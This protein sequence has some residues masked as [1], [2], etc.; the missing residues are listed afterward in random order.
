MTAFYEL[1]FNIKLCSQ[2]EV[3]INTNLK[4]EVL[5]TWILSGTW[6]ELGKK[7]FK[8]TRGVSTTWIANILLQI[9]TQI[10]KKILK[11]KQSM[12]KIYWHAPMQ[13]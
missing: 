5:K 8:K 7:L 9:T 3:F 10:C 12:V 2:Y 4:F 11:S 1:L 13:I 6:E